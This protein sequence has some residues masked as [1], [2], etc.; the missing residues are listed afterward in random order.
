MRLA[1]PSLAFLCVAQPI[2]IRISLEW[3]RAPRLLL[4][5]VPPVSIRV[6]GAIGRPIPVR[7]RA[8]RQ[9]VGV[10]PVDLKGIREPVP[11]R[12]RREWAGTIAELKLIRHAIAV[13]IR[14]LAW[15]QVQASAAQCLESLAPGV[16]EV[17]ARGLAIARHQVLQGPLPGLLC[18]AEGNVPPLPVL[19]RQLGT[20]SQQAPSM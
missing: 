5:A 7:V 16:Q 14:A 19:C 17:L 6:F 11:V 12:V 13:D 1:P 10:A 15:T 2:A 4:E 20:F 3:V 8:G 18:L 9:E